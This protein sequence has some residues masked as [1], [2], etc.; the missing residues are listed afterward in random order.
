MWVYTE[1]PY[2]EIFWEVLENGRRLFLV[3]RSGKYPTIY[4]RYVW[5]GPYDGCK[6]FLEPFQL[7]IP[8]Y[9]HNPLPVFVYQETPL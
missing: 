5:G 7:C 4:S 6:V 9:D 8:D 1:K 3:Y 2:S